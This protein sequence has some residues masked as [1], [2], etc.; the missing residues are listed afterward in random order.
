[1][2]S[3]RRLTTSTR[4]PPGEPVRPPIRQGGTLPDYYLDPVALAGIYAD[5]PEVHAILDRT[6]RLRAYAWAPDAGELVL[7]ETLMGHQDDLEV[8]IMYLLISEIIRSAIQRRAER[9]LPH[10]AMYDTFWGAS[11]GL[12]YFKSRLGFKPY[13]VRWVWSEIATPIPPAGN[14]SGPNLST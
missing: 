14:R 6:S 8:G 5:R 13:T 4:I 3:S 12:A 2:P 10:W 1:M 7:I 9:G 11:T